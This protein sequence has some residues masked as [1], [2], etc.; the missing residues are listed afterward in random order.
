MNKTE[1][2]I[3]TS[4]IL[5]NDVNKDLYEY[6][7]EVTPLFA[8][9]VR[10]TIHH[11]RH[12]LNGETETKYRTRLKNDYNVTNRFAKAVL[13]TAKN[14]LKLSKT[15]G[16]YLYS[17]YDKKI[18]SVSTKII[19]TKVAL[20]NPKTAKGRIKNLKTRLFWLEMRKNKLIQ[21]KNN[22][23][24]P[25][26]TLGTKKLLKS[27]KLKF[28]EKRDNQIVYIGDKNEYLGNQQFQISYD[29][30]YNKFTYKLR[31]E[32]EYI[33]D[34][35]YISGRFVLKDKFA[36]KEI[37]KTVNNPK[38]SPLSFR[39]IKKDNVLYLQIMYRVVAELNTRSSNGVL[40]VDFN[41]GFITISE[42]DERGKLL[43]HDRINYIHK[44]K[45][46]VTKNSMHHLVRDLVDLAVKS[47]KDIVV[48]D[49]KSLN[50]NKREKTER[51]HYN[52]MINTLKFG[53]FRDLLQMKCDKCGVTLVTVNPYNTSKIA[54]E[55]YCYDMKLNIHS[56]ASYVIAR[57]FYNLD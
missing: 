5:Y 34:S 6:F 8:F 43:N 30:K 46:G 17:T 57:R 35:K 26:L 39:L 56:G 13:K 44:G 14:L 4:C 47:G 33:K 55:K 2:T 40:G 7:E 54:K 32:N 11:L 31:L 23:S 36:K 24:K 25:M 3:V 48:E 29:K 12:K 41:K 37:L 18:K 20:N 15:A 27:D 16:D 50:K 51:K 21:L 52:R 53:R 22:G 10:R 38:S 42:I 49:L 19:K 45:V 1:T 28:L 9:L